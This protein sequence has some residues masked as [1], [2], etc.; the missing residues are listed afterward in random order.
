M[1]LPIIL[2]SVCFSINIHAQDCKNLYYLQSGKTVE[3]TIYSKKGNVTGKQVYNIGEVTSN[4]GIIGSTITSEMIDKDGKSINKS[5]NK[6]QCNNGV[7][8]MDLKMFIQ[9]PQLEQIKNADATGSVSYL[10]YPVDMKTGDKLKDA[11]FNM[12]YTANGIGSNLTL[13]MS[14]RFV[15][16]KDNV[17]SPAGSW[18]AFKIGYKSKIKMKVAGIG[19]PINMEVTEWYVPGFGIVKTESKYGSTLITS[20]K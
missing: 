10:E 20:I 6:I 1:K 7:L 15:L 5:T 19:I 13:N 2:A 16:G 17:S 11:D 3:M 12:D 14:D 4:N 9:G 18:D 8:M